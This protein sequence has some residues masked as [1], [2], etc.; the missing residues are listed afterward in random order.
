MD[1]IIITKLKRIHHKSGDILHAI[2]SSDMGFEKFG[3]AYFSIIKQNKIKGWKKHN[4]MVLNLVVPQGKIKFVMYDGNAFEEHIVSKDNYVR[5]TVKDGIWM[6]FM[7]LDQNNI[8]LNI[9]NIE[10]DPNEADSVDLNK[11]KYDKWYE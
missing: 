3:E 9:A 11:I 4:K 10:H 1:G 7:G 5:I 6:A 8:L 2:K